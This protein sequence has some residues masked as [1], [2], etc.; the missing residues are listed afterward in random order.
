MGDET[1]VYGYDIETKAQ[2]S[3]WVSRTSPRHKKAWQ[4]QSKL[5]VM[6]TVSFDCEGIIHHEFLLRGQSEQG[7][8]SEGDV[9]VD[10]GSEEKKVRFVE[11]K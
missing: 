9:K 8:L 11:G 10:R 2:S 6:L 1:W 3:Q 5:K 4:V 7:I